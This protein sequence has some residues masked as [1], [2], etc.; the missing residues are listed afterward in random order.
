MRQCWSALFH[1]VI[2]QDSHFIFLSK[3]HYID[4]EVK[5]DYNILW[6]SLNSEEWK[7]QSYMEWLLYVVTLKRVIFHSKTSDISLQKGWHFTPKRVIFHSEKGDIALRIEWH[8]TPKK[9]HFTP[10]RVTF[11]FR[12][13]T[14]QSKKSDISL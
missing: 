1:W 10:K 12:R 8:F 14:F 11:H 5:M 9:W 3:P 13:V 2:W 6:Y 7:Y 4:A